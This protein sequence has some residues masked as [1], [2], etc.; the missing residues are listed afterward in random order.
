MTQ[1]SERENNTAGTVLAVLESR[2]NRPNG[3]WPILLLMSLSV[4]LVRAGRPN[5]KMKIITFLRGSMSFHFSEA[6]HA[7]PLDDTLID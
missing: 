1:V 2:Q 7:N 6:I 5:A 4:V 3:Y